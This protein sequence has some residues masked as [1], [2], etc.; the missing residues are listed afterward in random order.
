MRTYFP[1]DSCL[2]RRASGFTLMEVIVAVLIMGMTLAALSTVLRTAVRAW[3][4]G[5]GAEEIF[6]TA[7]IAQDIVRRDLDNM[8]YLN[9]LNYNKTYHQ[10][11]EMLTQQMMQQGG[12]GD[13]D[14]RRQRRERRQDRDS[15]RS[16]SQAERSA[17]PLANLDP[18]TISPPIDLA[19]RGTDGDKT[20]R[21]SFVRGFHPRQENDAVAWGL[22]RVSYYIRDKVLYRTQSDAF[23]L[24][25]E[26]DY[27]AMVV[28]PLGGAG[29][30][31]D[32]QTRELESV[33]RE[34]TDLFRRPEA[35]SE[36]AQQ[37]AADDSSGALPPQE[38]VEEPLCEG[39]EIFD[40][41]Y[42][43]YRD[44]DWVEAKDWDSQQRKHRNPPD[45][46]EIVGGQPQNNQVFVNNQ[47]LLTSNN[48]PDDLPGYIA[49][50]IGVRMPTGK[51]RLY[52]YTIFHSLP[53]A[54]ETD[55]MRDET[56]LKLARNRPRGMGS[57]PRSLSR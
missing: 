51:G 30:T 43:F 17:D 33:R 11:V 28:P 37:V 16:R 50:Q 24:S 56:D 32:K 38:R 45:E 15:G 54:Q 10:Q 39:V 9:A 22:R 44:G 53:L 7:R 46:N 31:A 23:G 18:S 3:R 41:N 25:G 14:R 47:P 42:G 8:V 48:R 5:H 57:R 52:S 26:T 12:L 21:L 1:H 19:L 2:R 4:T 6:Q 55:V 13:P 27:G 35:G 29:I 36:E 40:V 49:I 34:V 20:D